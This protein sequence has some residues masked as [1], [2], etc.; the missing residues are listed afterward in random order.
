MARILLVVVVLLALGAGGGFVW[1]GLFPPAAHS[2][3]VSH[4]LP[5]AQLVGQ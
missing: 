5:V 3:A 1:C 4:D 2:V